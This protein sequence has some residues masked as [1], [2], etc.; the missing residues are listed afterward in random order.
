MTRWKLLCVAEAL[1]LIVLL[2]VPDADPSPLTGTSV[3]TS[4]S[5]PASEAVGGAATSAFPVE[6][7][8]AVEAPSA[9][10][11]TTRAWSSGAGLVTLLGSISD[12]SGAPVTH[13][14]VSIVAGEEVIERIMTSQ[15][16]NAFLLSDRAPG[17]I[18]LRVTAS[19]FEPWS[20]LVTLRESPLIQRLEV[21]LQRGWRIVLWVRTPEG[22]LL[23]EALHDALGRASGMRTRV[24]ARAEP[25]DA[26]RRAKD[27]T[28][29]S[30]PLASFVQASF[31]EPTLP[32]GCEGVLD[33]RGE[34][35][36]VVS[37]WLD[38]LLIG[39]VPIR[40]GMTEATLE[41]APER[42]LSGLSRVRLRA[43][44]AASLEPLEGVLVQLS[45]PWGGAGVSGRTDADGRVELTNVPPENLDLELELAGFA[46]GY[47]EL[48]VDPRS[49]L[50]LGELPLSRQGTIPMRIERPD[51][52]PWA[53]QMF[54][55]FPIE[56]WSRPEA[57]R[58][59]SS[60][61]D[62]AGRVE[63]RAGACA[64]QAIFGGRAGI[65]LQAATWR[66]G[67]AEAAERLIRLR[68]GSEVR[69]TADH[70]VGVP[71]WVWLLDAE[72][73]LLSDGWHSARQPATWVLAPA[74]YL[75]R[76][77]DLDRNLL[78]TLDLRV[79]AGGGELRV[80]LP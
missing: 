65:A 43:V 15:T 6:R 16:T 17:T 77:E 60:R 35:P 7:S 25:A 5:F 28:H 10:P 38:R 78:T 31:Q 40:A 39:S 36:F 27:L 48:Q 57:P 24:E 69:L 63:A 46:E 34:P 41:V 11:A 29:P 19:G 74:T 9:E 44:D 79:P 22:R 51:G 20:E 64:Y 72:G 67:S 66:R 76:V 2:W 49:V 3:S 59:S 54:R 45:P 52:S 80:A 50:D 13:A 55:W 37:V 42:I 30:S 4:P 58:R 71:R 70:E 32:R 47:R 61:T 21:R 23:R 73:N 75:L 26:D 33:I 8:A 12:E 62:S 56:G 14:S 1:L 18:E 68:E 53:D